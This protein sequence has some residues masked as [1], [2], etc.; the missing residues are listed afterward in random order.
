M[1]C[2]M[3]TDPAKNDAGQF[4]DNLESTL[5]NQISPCM[6]VCEVED[7]KKRTDETIDALVDDICQLTH[8]AVMS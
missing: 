4:L 1:D 2:W 6:T 8:C 3:P 5:D 7:I